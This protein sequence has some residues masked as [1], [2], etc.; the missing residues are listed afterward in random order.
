MQIDKLIE[1]ECLEG[2]RIR[3]LYWIFELLQSREETILKYRRCIKADDDGATG[4]EQ[5]D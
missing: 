3:V 2:V 4:G 5:A 1:N